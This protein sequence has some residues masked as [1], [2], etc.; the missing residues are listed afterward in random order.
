M[1]RSLR[2]VKKE[3]RILG[4]DTCNPRVIIGAVVRG[5][6]Y[7]DGVVVIPPNLNGVQM[8]DE[9]AKTKYFP[10]L[11]AIMVHD[12]K[13]RLR[14]KP[15]MSKT[16][17][18]TII[19]NRQITGKRQSGIRDSSRK[20]T[21]VTELDEPS[22][23]RILDLTQRRGFLPEPLRIAHLLAKLHTFWDHRSR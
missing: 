14:S 2:N 13:S 10:E 22:L 20:F 7:L 9:I 19:I 16:G 21:V 5:G 17:L 11:R 12:P 23:A 8:A 3:I 6:L 1:N 4:L 18:P 15:T